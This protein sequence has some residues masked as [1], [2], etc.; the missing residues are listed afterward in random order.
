MY[1]KFNPS[2]AYVYRFELADSITVHI[3]PNKHS[4]NNSEAYTSVFL[5]NLEEML[6]NVMYNRSSTTHYYVVKS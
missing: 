6:H 3:E 2:I 4:F 5:E 1:L